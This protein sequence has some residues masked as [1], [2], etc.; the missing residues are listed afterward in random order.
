MQQGIQQGMQQGMQQ[1]EAL[2]L[3][4]LLTRRF[5]AL[6]ATQLANIAAA[7]SAQLESWGDRVLEAKSL[8]EV[9]GDT[10]H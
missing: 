7:S 3:Q 4:R 1:G 6:S 5:G 8:D 9:F 2:L 10:R